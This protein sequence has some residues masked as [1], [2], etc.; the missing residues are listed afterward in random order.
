MQ[1]QQQSKEL[2]RFQIQT[3][4]TNKKPKTVGVA[5][6]KDGDSTYSIRLWMFSDRYYMIQSK[7]DALKYIIM[8]REEANSNYTKNKYKWRIVGNGL[9]NSKIGAIELHFDL[10][11]KPLYMNLYPES[12]VDKNLIDDKIEATTF[13]EQKARERHAA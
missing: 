11:S 6:L 4:E 2:H 10:L 7:E 9:F 3:T 5:Y 8:S 1:P 13:F 12:Y